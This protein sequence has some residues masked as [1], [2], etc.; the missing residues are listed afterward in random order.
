MTST[1]E[2]ETITFTLRIQGNT[3]EQVQIMASKMGISQNSLIQMFIRVGLVT[4]GNL[5]DHQLAELDRVLS[6]SP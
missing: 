4:F 5:T 2:K 3:N 1:T 6:Q